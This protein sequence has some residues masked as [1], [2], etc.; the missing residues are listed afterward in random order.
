MP[1]IEITSEST[2]LPVTIGELVADIQSDVEKGLA[3]IAVKDSELVN[4]EIQKP[5]SIDIDRIVEI[6]ES[7]DFSIKFGKAEALALINTGYVDTFDTYGHRFE[8]L[9]AEVA[10]ALIAAGHGYVVAYEFPRFAGLDQNEA[11]L[12]L[13]ATGYGNAIANLPEVFTNIDS[14]SIVLALADKGDESTVEA[15]LEHFHGI[16]ASAAQQLISRDYADTLIG[17]MYAFRRKDHAD[18]ARALIRAGRGGSVACSLDN[19]KDTDHN[20][21]AHMLIDAGKGNIVLCYLHNFQGIDQ[22]ALALALIDKNMVHAV[23]DYLYMFTDRLNAN[24]AHALIDAGE[25]RAV[26]YKLIE[27]TGLDADIGTTLIG[28]GFGDH[29]INGRSSFVE[30]EL[31]DTLYADSSYTYLRGGFSR[32]A[33]GEMLRRRLDAGVERNIHDASQWLESFQMPYKW[34]DVDAIKASDDKSGKLDD[35]K[36]PLKDPALEATFIRNLIYSDV[37]L[38]ER[39][40]Y[41]TTE[42]QSLRDKLAIVFGADASLRDELKGRIGR[43]RAIATE[44]LYDTLLGD[45]EVSRQWQEYQEAGGQKKKFFKDL[46]S[47]NDIL[48]QS[49][50]DETVALQAAVEEQFLAELLTTRPELAT[51]IESKV[52]KSGEDWFYFPEYQLLYQAACSSEGNSQLYKQPDFSIDTLFGRAHAMVDTYYDHSFGH[53]KDETTHKLTKEE[54]VLQLN[55]AFENLTAAGIETFAQP[56]P[57][58]NDEIEDWQ[59]KLKIA[60]DRMN[61]DGLVD[62][63]TKLSQ[64]RRSRERYVRD[65]QEWLRRHAT[66]QSGHLTQAWGDRAT[67]LL[68]GI[69]DGVGGIRSWQRVNALGLEIDRLEADGMLQIQGMSREYVEAQKDSVTELTRVLSSRDTIEALSK[70]KR[71]REARDWTDKILPAERVQTEVGNKTYSIEIFDKDDPRGF[72]IGEDTGCCMT[73]DGVSK[74]CIRAGYTRRDAGFLGVYLPNGDLLAQ[75]FWYVHPDE[76]NVLVMDNIEANEGRDM[77]NIRKIYQETLEKYLRSHAELHINEVRVGVGYTDINLGGLRKVKNPKTLGEGI[78][79]DARDQRRMLRLEAAA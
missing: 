79:T 18:I 19:F 64:M 40:T 13:I 7:N 69:P 44:H 73:I 11:A 59:I 53:S 3:G 23:A 49:F 42:K 74:S 45:P 30:L 28:A 27:F 56:Q 15:F 6:L 66:T 63:A 65:T 31:P 48:Q 41:G 54:L 1:T 58:S 71:W 78:Y 70:L 47:G 68:E 35:Y 60:F 8:G 25:S 61:R 16:S 24:V 9:D 22:N 43:E 5:D 52:V 36:V 67:A 21:I 39:L 12:K 51:L 20:E 17:R 29:V 46:M 33:I 26:A 72:T 50:T 32:S 77:E 75:S 57:P 55:N 2:E 76:P 34:F 62:A 14:D 10:Y 38:R 37:S 4:P